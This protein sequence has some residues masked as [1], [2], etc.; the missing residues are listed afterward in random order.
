[1]IP[2]GKKRCFFQIRGSAIRL[3][4]IEGCQGREKRAG[5]RGRENGID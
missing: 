4:G 5:E 3:D 2:Q 1:M